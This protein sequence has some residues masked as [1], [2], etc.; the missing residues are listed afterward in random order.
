MT[1]NTTNLTSATG[2]GDL[3]SFAN[4]AT[5]GVLAVV[6]LIVIFIIMLVAL[7]RYDFDDA[8]LASSWVTFLLSI[9][10]RFAGFLPLIWALGFLAIAGFATLWVF[11]TKRT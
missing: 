9:F 10:L 3:V 1:Y 8:L 6:M 2:I 11:T 4:N 7:K 5:D